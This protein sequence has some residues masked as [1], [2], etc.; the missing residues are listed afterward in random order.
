MSGDGYTGKA[1]QDISGIAYTEISILFIHVLFTQATSSNCQRLTL[2]LLVLNKVT[3]HHVQQN[4]VNTVSVTGGPSAH[5]GSE[6]LPRSDLGQVFIFL[7]V[8]FL[9]AALSAGGTV[10]AE[11][12]SVNAITDQKRPRMRVSKKVFFIYIFFFKK[13]L[14]LFIAQ[15]KEDLN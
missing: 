6:T 13:A 14:I 1:I 8:W 7:R 5:Q 3:N 15:R 10:S 2:T 11:N 4:R 9:A 12:R